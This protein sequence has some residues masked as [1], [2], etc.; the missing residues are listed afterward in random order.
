MNIT[1]NM[2]EFYQLVSNNNNVYKSQ[3][4]EYKTVLTADSDVENMQ[5]D[6]KEFKKRVRSLKNYNPN[7]Y[8]ESKMS[9]Q[10]DNFKKAYNGLKEK[11]KKI[12]DNEE[13]SKQMES[14]EGLIKDNEKSLKK[15]GIKYDDKGYLEYDDSKIEEVDSKT[16]KTLFS[17]KESF[18]YKAGKLINKVE[19]AVEKTAVKSEKVSYHRTV[20]YTDDELAFAYKCSDIQEVMIGMKSENDFIKTVEDNVADIENSIYYEVYAESVQ[21]RTDYLDGFVKL[22][23]ELVNKKSESCVEKMKEYSKNNENTLNAIGITLD[24]NGYMKFEQLSVNDKKITDNV[25]KLFGENASYQEG[26]HSM[27]RELLNKTLK[28]EKLGIT[29]DITI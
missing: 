6:M 25:E 27:A 24:E 26:I 15:I 4:K 5:K 9:M 12:D 13:V 14:L 16:L 19:D 28:T 18:I 7:T 17:G 21:Y 8:V 3:N 23:N 2:N 11:Y 20:K 29:V 22:Y 10:L 1:Y